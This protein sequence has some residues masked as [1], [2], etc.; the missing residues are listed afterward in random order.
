MK[1][2]DIAIIN[3]SFWP[4]YPVVG[5]GLLRLA[6]QLVQNNQK[7]V[8]IITQNQSKNLKNNLNNF[9]RGNGVKFFITWAISNSSSNLFLRIL[10]TLFFVLMVFTALLR[11]RPKKIYI[12]TDPPILVPFLV[13]IYSK[14]TK[15]EYIYH[16]QDIHPEATNS[17]FKVNFLL[18]YILKK[19][20]NITMRSANLLITLN[21]KMKSVIIE[22]SK[23]KKKIFIINNPSVEF[24]INKLK[25]KKIGFSFTGN[26]GRAQRILLLINSINQYLQKGGKLEF[27]F[28]GAGIYVN[29]ILE[30][31]NYS[32]FV[33]YHGLVSAEQASYISGNYAWALAP[34]EDEITNYA[35]PSKLSTYTCVGAKI[36]AICSKST[37]VAAW[38]KK[39]KS[40]HNG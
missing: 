26:L 32:H 14:I 37:S 39:K 20:D 15:T 22:R 27:V 35:F 5:E 21:E 25:S 7:K 29:K 4:F 11:T 33:S 10:D 18:I 34:I 9:K 2:F 40:R 1:N 13:L 17:L 23:T 30:L 38:I 8:V 16:L 19:I 12:S 36:L 6:E 24:N 28:A 3:R 31:S